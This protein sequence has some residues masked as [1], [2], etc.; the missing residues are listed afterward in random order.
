MWEFVDNDEAV[1][2]VDHFYSKGLPAIDACRYL[3]AKAALCWRKFEGDYRDDITAIVVY[4][5]D[6]VAALEQERLRHSRRSGAAFANLPEPAVLASTVHERRG[7]IGLDGA[8]P[9]EDDEVDDE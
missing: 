7:S 8:T 5:P 4:L 6:V 2:I 9:L 3:I 1:T